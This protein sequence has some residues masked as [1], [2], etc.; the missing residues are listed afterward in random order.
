MKII[1][2]EL[3]NYGQIKCQFIPFRETLQL[4]VGKNNAGKSATLL[5]LDANSGEELKRYQ[6]DE[7]SPTMGLVA[8][9]E[10]TD[11]LPISDGSAR[12]AIAKD[13]PVV[14]F[15]ID[16]M[17][18]LITEGRLMW[19]SFAQAAV[20]TFSNT[21]PQQV[22][23][24]THN[25]QAGFQNNAVLGNL[26]DLL[27]EYDDAIRTTLISPHRR[28][29][30]QT[31][32]RAAKVF[33]KD[34]AE[35]AAY[36]QTL[37]GDD[38]DRFKDIESAFC[39]LF[40]EFDR[41]IMRGQ[42]EQVSLHLRRTNDK[43]D[44]HINNCGSGLEQTLVL[45]GSIY[46][47]DEKSALLLDEPHNFLHPS[48][49]RNLA[50]VLQDSGRRIIAATHSP[51]LINY[52]KPDQ[53]LLIQGEGQPY[54]D[55][56]KRDT[57][58]LLVNAHKTIGFQNSDALFHDRLV[59]VEGR[60]DAAVFPILL[61]KRGYSE[62]RIAA[63]GF[64]VI[65]GLEELGDTD[66][67]Q[68]KIAARLALYERL[69]LSIGRAEQKH[70]YMLDGDRRNIAPLVAK[71]NI[72]GQGISAHFTPGRELE[73]LFID[74]KLIE[75]AILAQASL[76]DVEI[77]IDADTV[78]SQITTFLQL[79]EDDVRFAKL[80][81]AGRRP[82]STFADTVKGSRLL[83]YVYSEYKLP[84]EKVLSGKLL[85]SAMR[86]GDERLKDFLLPI[87]TLLDET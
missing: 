73:N 59:F 26:A 41:I 14:K 60:S 62:E 68:E 1:G 52:V 9:F 57:S 28:I 23:I 22:N 40:P 47:A 34:G 31:P 18:R 69:L 21:R 2:F 74:A 30:F 82:D 49:E 32:M 17:T 75:C 45:L 56:Q 35:M 46:I 44:L 64:P 12:E 5:F 19:R 7:I 66:K 77:T 27:P 58:K 53:V 87:T 61:R 55:F 76:V 20:Y 83:A 80:F 4:L 39:R 8:S 25:I 86:E 3:R 67:D 71:L 63:I 50:A 37:N 36:L 85:A 29:S 43:K 6:S 65:N 78:S 24:R 11:R 16:P 70:I 51:I 72:D 33:P 81:P 54:E 84:Y 13:A 48:A 79:P 42:G 10:P 38:R 15:A